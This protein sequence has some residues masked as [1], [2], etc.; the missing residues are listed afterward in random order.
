MN[1]HKLGTKLTLVL[2]FGILI[3]VFITSFIKSE[4]ERRLVATILT[5]EVKA[6]MTWFSDQIQLMSDSSLSL[7]AEIAST[8][9]TAEAVLSRDPS[10][11]MQ[12]VNEQMLT[13][14]SDVDFVMV[15]DIDG[16]VLSQTNSYQDVDSIISQ[17]NVREALKGLSASYIEPGSAVRLA[18][19]SSAPIKNAQGEIIG[20]VS[21]GYRIDTEEFVDHLKY[22]TGSEISIFSGNER[23]AT[24]MRLTNGE[25]MTSVPMDPSVQQTVLGNGQGVVQKVTRSDSQYM[26][27]YNPIY[28]TGGNAIGALF[29]GKPMDEI[30]ATMNRNWQIASLYIIA[31]TLA[32]AVLIAI[33]LRKVIVVRIRKLMLI[34]NEVK[35]GNF[36]VNTFS[37][38]KDELGELTKM[39]GDM[40]NTINTLTVDL[41][42]LT[43]NFNEL[44]QLDSRMD[45]S[46]FEG[47]YKEVADSVNHMASSFSGDMLTT[48]ECIG[49]ISA[50]DFE[51]ELAPQPGQ[52]IILN[53]AVDSLRDALKSIN[54]EIMLLSSQAKV[55]NLSQRV[56]LENYKG[57]W[58]NLMSNLNELL[59]EIILPI[60]EASG[61]L[62]EV[63]MGNFSVRVKGNYQ[64][65]FL[66]IKSSINETVTNISSYIHEIS[67]VLSSMSNDD[68]TRDITREYIGD[69]SSIKVSLNTIINKFNSMI[70]D[71]YAASEHVAIGSKQVAQT[72]MTLSQGSVEQTESVDA[73]N[74]MISEI[75]LNIT[76]NAASAKEAESLSNLSKSSAMQGDLD[77]K[78]MLAAMDS[79]KDS[80]NKISNIIKVIEDIAFQ[81]NLLALN[82]AVEAARAGEHGKGFAVVAEEV[83]DLAGRS[84]NAAKETSQL[85]SES[86][87]RVSDGTTIANTTAGTLQN[88]V[89]E[90]T[91]VAGIIT[92]INA[93]SAIQSKSIASIAGNVSRISDVVQSN[94]ATSEESAAASEELSSQADV[95]RNLISVF[96]TKN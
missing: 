23:I 13:L 45:N 8:D 74:T 63:S 94:S 9:F 92:N 81:T 68:L 79:I 76:Q 6:E 12:S 43:K 71:M 17:E 59:Q 91:K 84:Q 27:N 48:L 34:M 75:N 28:D 29:L 61:V 46:K 55:G 42:T 40:I 72:S 70:S 44:G 54:N 60:N 69:F 95:L 80:S 41:K 21:S 33:Y 78:E 62:N 19:V 77:M 52:K 18:V 89:D 38:S 3:L 39:A 7:A 36:N 49:K 67:D 56:P 2:V 66:L 90:V 58:T 4:A 1:F 5:N 47:A 26:A 14:Q 57:D 82:A 88:I 20:C 22:L 96:K 37:T 10:R 93:A 15:S 73:L 85:I 86:I 25:R 11:I 16:T 31:M 32:S 51:S 30:N 83:R 53:Q 64:G 87:E 24:T 65:E 35:N 50:G